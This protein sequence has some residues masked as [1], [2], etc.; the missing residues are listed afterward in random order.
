MV[1]LAAVASTGAAASPR[2]EIYPRDLDPVRALRLT[3]AGLVP[4]SIGDRPGELTVRQIQDRVRAR[5]P[6]LPALPEHP[7]LDRLLAE[8]GFPLIYQ[9]QARPY[10]GKP[11]SGSWTRMSS[12]QRRSTATGMTVWNAGSPELAAALRAEQRLARTIEEGGFRALT[13]RTDRYPEARQELASRLSARECNVAGRF[14]AQ[15][16]ALVEARPKPTWETVLAADAADPNSRDA[17]K[18]A[19]FTSRTWQQ[20]RPELLALPDRRLPLLL[21]DAAPLARYRAM[22]LLEELAER[23]RGGAGA[24]WLLCPM[25]DPGQLPRLDDAVVPVAENEWII[26]PDAW[27]TNEHRGGRPQR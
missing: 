11:G 22:E 5:F 3:Q 18:L 23:A 15:L 21:F 4:P 24:V 20:L 13:V 17:L 12:H 6:A 16:R 10:H 1:Q 7:R 25:E 9:G 27:V 2:L 14:M 19:E 26:L 8:A